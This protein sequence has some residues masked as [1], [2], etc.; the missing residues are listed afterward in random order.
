[1]THATHETIHEISETGIRLAY[2]TK[3]GGYYPAHWHE[4]M[5]ILYP[6]NGDA[7]I[8]IE[9]KIH[10]LKIRQITVINP[11]QVHSTS[12]SSG[13]VMFL[14]VHISEKVLEKYLP[15]VELY[16]I[17]CYPDEVSEKQA[18]AYGEICEKLTK[19]IRLYMED[20]SAADMESEG[21]VLQ[22]LALLIR[23]FS[24]KKTEVP[25]TQVDTLTRERLMK[26]IDWVDVHFAE[27]IS[28]QDAAKL[29]GLGVEYF[30][31][32]FKKNMNA[33]FLQYVNEVRVTRAY[34]DLASCDLSVAEIA[35]KNGLY[36]QKLFNR[37]FKAIYGCTP[38]QVRGGHC[39]IT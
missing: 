19:I 31:R 22:I 25:L 38:S 32:F 12:C 13:V 21:L 6:L 7:Q 9:G 27:P 24:V 14:C 16:R 26:V 37:S 30:C 10:P 39:E 5:E 8:D 34:Q 29:L 15:D 36:N 23:H 18:A 33:T 4:E 11:Y 1:M 3:P 2:R 20:A 28:T 35:E 17:Y